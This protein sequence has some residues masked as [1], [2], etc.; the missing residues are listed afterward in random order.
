V[1]RIIVDLE[2][3][4]GRWSVVKDIEILTKARRTVQTSSLCDWTT[5]AGLV[6]VH[7]R[8][9]AL[10]RARCC[11]CHIAITGAIATKSRQSVI[12]GSRDIHTEGHLGDTLKTLPF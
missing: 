1:I 7:D 5:Q 3:R 11:R 8:V 12:D 9:A 6:K 10:E 2:V 4:R